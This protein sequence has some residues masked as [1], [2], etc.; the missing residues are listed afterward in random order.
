MLA[1]PERVNQDDCAKNT[2]YQNNYKL[3]QEELPAPGAVC[4][5]NYRE[6]DKLEN[7]R[8]CDIRKS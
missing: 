6:S 1:D 8:F 3:G 5:V 7:Y 2:A 4:V